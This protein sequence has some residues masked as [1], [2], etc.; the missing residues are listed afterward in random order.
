MPIKWC[1]PYV[2]CFSRSQHR[3]CLS[4]VRLAVKYCALMFWSPFDK[5][6]IESQLI[7]S[8]SGVAFRQQQFFWD[9]LTYMHVEV[10]KNE[11]TVWQSSLNY[12]CV[13]CLQELLMTAFSWWINHC[14]I[15]LASRHLRLVECQ[16]R[17]GRLAVQAV[18]IQQL[19][20]CMRICSTY[21]LSCH[22]YSGIYSVFWHCSWTS[23]HWILFK[24][25]RFCSVSYIIC[26]C[27]CC[28]F[29][30]IK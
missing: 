20:L 27:T 10:L 25:N 6:H 16:S 5:N 8:L 13:F 15:D 21:M 19:S 22:W 1:H 11:N 30:C 17:I 4:T 28:Y 9:S 3:S 2:H 24:L 7:V 18:H 23:T 29:Y 12:I 26:V 14:L